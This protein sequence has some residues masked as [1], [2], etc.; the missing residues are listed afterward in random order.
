MN[1]IPIQDITLISSNVPEGEGSTRLMMFDDYLNT[2]TEFS[3][4]IEVEI[5]FNNCDRVALFN[6][7]AYS[8]DLEL[9]DD[10]TDTVVMTSFVDLEMSDGEYQQWIVEPVYIYAN[11]TLKISIN[12]LGSTAKCGLCAVGL[13][14]NIGVT[15]YSPDLGFLDFSKKDVNDFGNTY[16]KA[17]N[18]AKVLRLRTMIDIGAVDDVFED[19]VAVRGSLVIIEGNQGDTNYEAL[20]VCGFFENWS[21]VIDNPTVA[22]IDYDT[23]GVI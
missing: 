14:T 17:G 2:Q 8:V 20:R 4:L 10:D 22:W 9:T 23:K 11:A 16:L 18:W 19:L 21:I 6:I 7:D 12:K 3:D 13:S 5:E 1:L 15:Q